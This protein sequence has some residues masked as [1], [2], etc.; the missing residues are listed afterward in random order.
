MISLVQINYI[1]AKSHVIYKL[2]NLYEFERI[3]YT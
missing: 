2:H 1:V 3:T